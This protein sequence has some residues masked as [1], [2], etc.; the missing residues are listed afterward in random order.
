MAA[1]VHETLL[2]IDGSHAVFRSFFAVRGL[3][4]PTGMPTGAV[5]G[6]AAMILKLVRDRR[7]ARVAV[8][9]DSPGPTH[10]HDLDPRYKANRPEMPA[11]LQVQ[12]PICQQVAAL[13]GLPVLRQDGL[14]ADDLIATLAHRG[15]EAGF[16]VVVVSGDKDLMQLV[17]DGGE[18]PPIRQLDDGKDKLYDARAVEDKWGVPPPRVR[19]LLAIMG[20]SSD[21]VAGVR[22]IGEKGAARLIATWGHLDAI[23]ANLDAV[24]PAR[25]RELLRADE[26]QARRAW[27]LVGLVDDALLPWTIDDLAPRPPGRVAAARLFA[28]LGFKKLTAEFSHDEAPAAAPAS[29]AVPIVASDVELAQVCAA[30]RRAGAVALVTGTDR[31]D[32]A[33]TQPLFGAAIGVALSWGRDDAAWIPF[34]SGGPSRAALDA[35]LAPLLV[36][37][38]IARFGCGAKY[39]I[40]A[41]DRAGL[42]VGAL[43]GDA[44]LA[45]Y[46]DDPERHGHGLAAI[47]ADV[48]GETLPA[49]DGL[50]GKGKAETGWHAVDPARVAAHL[51]QKATTALRLCRWYVPQLK[52]S[53]V[54]AL[55]RDVEVPL[56]GV[57]ARMERHGVAL[58]LPEMARQSEWLAD[59][60]SIA[61]RAVWELAGGSFNVGSPRQLGEVLF[62]RLKLPARKRTQTGWSTDQSVLEGLADDHPI[63]AQVL[64]YRQLTKLRSTYTELLPTMVHPVTGRVHTWFGQATAATGRLSSIDPNLQ[65]IPVRSPEGR[66]IR[67]AFIAAPGHVLLSADYSQIE[68]R[69]MAH[70]ADDPGLQAAFHAGLDIHQQTAARMFNLLPSL[71]GPDQRAAAK[72]INFGILYG[73]GPQRLSREIGVSLKEAKAFIERYFER[74]PT[75]QR[76]VDATLAHARETGE[77]RTLFGRRRAVAGLTAQ[78]P[79]DRAQAE[80]IAVNTPVQ[81]TAADLIK[82]AMIEVDRRLTG[83][84]ARL[85]LQV[86]D[87]LVVEVPEADAEVTASVVREAMQAADLHGDGARMKVPLAVDVRWAA[88]WADAH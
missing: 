51:G 80:R 70:L 32:G 15:R 13:L 56:A 27:Q 85:L 21:N 31:P 87:E 11:E 57:L 88:S 23:Y 55:Y 29:S 40:L 63:V 10:R 74:F 45:S 43:A 7:P 50:I 33:R 41:L 16:E 77:V 46:L 2:L 68:L 5:Y 53:H 17:D 47:A 3:S 12:W 59:Q 42:L 30:V 83:T 75:V 64:R 28:E 58:D 84:A 39:E 18:R 20:D 48:L 52:E 78:S 79:A 9:F 26:A 36:D 71:V 81:G 34:G 37:P 24:E 1:S 4:S 72:T 61:E 73:M 25:I 44:M 35:S 60:A 82:R 22:G 66:A 69:V 49:D 67:R 6:F 86:H 14:E 65:N 62:E 54:H 19:D 76:W 38:A 8:C